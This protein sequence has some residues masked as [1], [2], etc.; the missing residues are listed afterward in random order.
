MWG[1]RVII[2]VK[3]RANVLNML[4]TSHPGIV[5]MKSLARG[6]VWWPGID[7]DIEHLVKSCTGCQMQQKAPSSVY[8]HPWEWPST[9]WERV[10]VDFVGPFLGRMFLIMVDA[11]SKWP[12][13]IEMKSTSAELKR[14]L[15]NPP[16][17][18][19]KQ[20]IFCK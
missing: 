14:M 3:L 7:S 18:E 15:F 8:V 17:F 6:Y 10:H 1:V 19:R 20:T 4:H 11:H 9:N 5:K 13:V 16:F 12:E 2:P